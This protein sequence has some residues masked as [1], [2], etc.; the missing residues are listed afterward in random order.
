MKEIL[1]IRPFIEGDF[2][3]VAALWQSC[4]LTRSWNDPKHDIDACRANPTSELFVGLSGD[5]IVSSVMAGNDGHRGV[6]YYVASAPEQQ[7]KGFAKQMVRHAEDWLN[8][9]GVWKVNLMIRDDNEKAR[10][11]YH[12][13]GYEEEARINMSRRLESA[14]KDQQL[15]CIVTYL[16]MD[17][18]PTRPAP[19]TPA[20]NIALLRCESPS[21]GFY[22]YL[23]ESVGAG[24]LWYERRVI[25]DA[26]LAALVIDPLVEI[27]VLYVDG[28]PAGYFELGLREM[29]E[30]ELA[31]FG[32]MGDF[33]GQ[34]LGSF[35]LR[36]AIDQAWSHNPDRLWVHT[37]NFDHP[38]ALAVYQRC[39]FEPYDQQTT[40]VDDPRILRPDLDWT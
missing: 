24:W 33:I 3:V 32:L 1:S 14:S 12:A 28:T 7:G 34:G 31:Y 19:P 27:F 26:T 16:Q 8:G 29:P 17:E 9:R 22:R 25:D 10:G 37:C 5:Q 36:Q 11:F 23:Y 20:K 38:D 2:E 39:G 6:V 15:E 35:L 18:A 40:Y 4:G 30:I 13:V 21:V